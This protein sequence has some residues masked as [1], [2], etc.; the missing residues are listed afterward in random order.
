MT[1][2]HPQGCRDAQPSAAAAERTLVSRRRSPGTTQMTS[3]DGPGYEASS[4]R[5]L[6][7]S[8]QLLRREAEQQPADFLGQAASARGLISLHASPSGK[9]GFPSPAQDA[10]LRT[11]NAAVCAAQPPRPRV[12]AQGRRQASRG[13][14]S[15]QSWNWGSTKAAQLSRCTAVAEGLHEPA[16]RL[17]RSCAVG[18]RPASASPLPR[19]EAGASLPRTVERRQPVRRERQLSADSI[20]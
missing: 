12:A 10:Q 15:T 19:Q 20:S 3:G 16:S 8:P 6:P 18:G 4:N 5:S 17:W 2:A 14:L 7:S 11:P 9:P 1:A 13:R